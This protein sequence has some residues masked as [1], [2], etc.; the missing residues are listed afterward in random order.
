MIDADILVQAGVRDTPKLNFKGEF[1]ISASLNQTTGAIE[2]EVDGDCYGLAWSIFFSND[3][4]MF[5]KADGLFDI[6]KPII[7]PVEIPLLQGC[8]GYVKDGTDDGLP[9]GLPDGPGSGSGMTGNGMNEASNGMTGSFGGFGEAPEQAA[10]SPAAAPTTTTRTTTSSSRTTTTT[11][12]S[13]TT[14]KPNTT[15]TS[16]ATSRSSTT[17]KPT[18]TSGP[19]CT[20]TPTAV[21]SPSSSLTCKKTVEQ[22]VVMAN[23]VPVFASADTVSSVD[24]CASMCLKDSKCLSFSYNSKKFCQL[25]LLA[26]KDIKRGKTSNTAAP[27]LTY[28]DKGCWKLS[29][30]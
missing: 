14:T 11:S 26:Y 25:Y 1:L 21:S 17:T 3:L 22:S 6:E 12:L 9:K 15:K 23:G 5:A 20:P 7:E 19:K 16:S 2:Y 8:I 30:C 10:E 27:S 24:L 29:K 28:Y 4:D 18:T 13:T